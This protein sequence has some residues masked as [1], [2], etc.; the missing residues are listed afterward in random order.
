[1]VVRSRRECNRWHVLMVHV[2]GWCW[3]P[4]R[5]VLYLLCQIK[6]NMFIY[7]AC[8]HD[9][10]MP[11]LDA[12]FPLA[13][14]PMHHNMIVGGIGSSR[15]GSTRGSPAGRAHTG[16]AGWGGCHWQTSRVSRP[17]SEF[18]WTRQAPEHF[19]L[20]LQMFNLCFNYIWCIKFMNWLQPLLHFT[21]F[22]LFISYPCYTL[23][24]GVE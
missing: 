22:N 16:G 14:T 17:P 24:Y 3:L 6:L 2:L 10:H 5:R 4:S 15:A 20:G 18:I 12:L 1:M 8:N 23:V 11:S 7:I 21:L 19:S 9:H 13:L